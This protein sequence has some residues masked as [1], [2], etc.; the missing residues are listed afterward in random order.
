MVWQT[1]PEKKIKILIQ[2]NQL[3][4][5]WRPDP[6]VN[7]VFSPIQVVFFLGYTTY[8]TF[9]GTVDYRGVDYRDGIPKIRHNY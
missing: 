3:V 1:G 7:H 6:V 4:G 2:D 5:G 9:L 8:T